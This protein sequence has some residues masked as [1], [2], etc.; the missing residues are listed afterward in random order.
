MAISCR[1]ALAVRVPQ[2]SCDIGG[3]FS[4]YL[5]FFPLNSPGPWSFGSP[6]A[7]RRALWPG[8]DPKNGNRVSGP[9]KRADI[10][11][12][13]SNYEGPFMRLLTFGTIIT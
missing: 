10:P 9:D 8:G 13:D 7:L 4:S 6:G 3:C 11:K 1:T 2:N 5:G 12:R